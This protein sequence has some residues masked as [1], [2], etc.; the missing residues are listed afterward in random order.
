M[1]QQ[2]ITEPLSGVFSSKLIIFWDDA[3]GEFASS[4]KGIELGDAER[5]HLD[6]IPVFKVRLVSERAVRGRRFLV[7]SGGRAPQPADE[8]LLDRRLRRSKGRGVQGDWSRTT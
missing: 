5:M 4:V 3:D 6:E 7:F 1:S 2:R 8:Y